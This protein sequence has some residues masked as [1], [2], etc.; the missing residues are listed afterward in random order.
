L[1]GLN[2]TDWSKSHDLAS[3]SAI[4]L[5]NFFE[6][7]ASELRMIIQLT[8]SQEFPG[9]I[10]SV[11]STGLPMIAG[12]VGNRALAQKIVVAVMRELTASAHARENRKLAAKTP[13][14][15]E[16]GN[17]VG[18]EQASVQQ[19]VVPPGGIVQKL[20]TGLFLFVSTK[21]ALIPQIVPGCPAPGKRAYPVPL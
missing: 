6:N 10:D 3:W 11:I 16:L 13:G 14:L 15:V 8:R 4:I 19:A 20:A 7:R 12:L 18:V 9:K 5:E 21:E 17:L 1:V 2:R